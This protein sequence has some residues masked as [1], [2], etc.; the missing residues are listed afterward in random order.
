MTKKTNALILRYGVSAFWK[1]KCVDSSNSLKLLLL[2]KVTTVELLKKNLDVLKFN[3]FS[4]C[5]ILYVFST[6]V[7]GIRFIERVVK[8]YDKILNLQSVIQK[9]GLFGSLILNMLNVI[10]HKHIVLFNTKYTGCVRL[11]TMLVVKKK[12]L[13]I[14]CCKFV[15]FIKYYGFI[16]NL[17][18]QKFF[19]LCRKAVCC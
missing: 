8:Y 10:G 4:H 17:Y 2:E 18:L 5:I 11:A 9:Y 14:L 15:F 13:V 16:K 6:Q 3:L 7:F 1:N 19:F 12:G